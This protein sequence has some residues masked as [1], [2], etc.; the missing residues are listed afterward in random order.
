MA[1][2]KTFGSDYQRGIDA[3]LE[4]IQNLRHKI[5]ATFTPECSGQRG[6]D[7]TDALHEAY[8]AVRLLKE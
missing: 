4:A 2:P 1:N 5:A 7:K 3:A 8:Q 6:Q